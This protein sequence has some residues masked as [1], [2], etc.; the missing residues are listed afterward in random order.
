MQLHHHFHICAGTIMHHYVTTVPLYPVPIN[1]QTDKT[2]ILHERFP[3]Q[4][5]FPVALDRFHK[6]RISFAQANPAGL[7]CKQR[8]S[9][10]QACES[11]L[12]VSNRCTSNCVQRHGAKTRAITRPCFVCAQ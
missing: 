1:V 8:P 4:R 5:L 9:G 11:K 6:L 2:Y 3:T 7:T 12:C 10:I